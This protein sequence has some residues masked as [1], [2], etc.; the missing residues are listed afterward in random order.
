MIES[1]KTP[2]EYLSPASAAGELRELF[3]EFEGERKRALAYLPAAAKE[4]PARRFPTVYLCH[5]GGGSEDDFFGGVEGKSGLTH[6]LDHLIGD[7]VLAPVLVV[8]P[9]YY[10]RGTENALVHAGAA[11]HL[12]EVFHREFIS[13]LIP[14]VEAALP[15]IPDRDHRAFGG[16]SMGAEATWST[17]AWGGRAAR[18]YLPMSGDFWAVAVKGG[19]D[20]TSETCC[21]LIEGM[22][23]GGMKPGDCFVFAAT[24]THDIAYPAMRPMVEELLKRAPW[25]GPGNL[26]WC[27][28]DGWHAYD[29]CRDY[30]AQ[31]LPV[32]F[33]GNA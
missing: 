9:T 30:I 4:D 28:S 16:F 18:Y 32:F 22:R 13:A 2:A 19:A 33:P 21:R 27:V 7:G 23:E 26:I 8:T 20:F 14:A 24:G 31:A 11:M 10:R 15:A 1:K 6:V 12:T 17:L 25:F 3:Y 29:W 5:G